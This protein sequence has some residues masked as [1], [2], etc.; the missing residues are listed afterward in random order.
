VT[1]EDDS[2]TIS[3]SNTTT[4]NIDNN[5]SPYNTG[6][7]VMSV[8]ADKNFDNN[9]ITL[10]NFNVTVNGQ[11]TTLDSITLE[12][13]NAVSATYNFTFTYDTGDG[14]E[15]TETGTMIF[16]KT[17]PDAGTYSVQLDNPIAG[18][19]TLETA[20]GSA[21]VG[22]ELNTSTPDNTQPA[23]AVTTIVE[24][25]GP[26]AE[27]GFYVQFT[28]FSAGNGSH[29]TLEGAANQ[30]VEG[31]LFSEGTSLHQSWVSVSGGSNGVAGD[32]VNGPDVLNF[33]LYSSNPTGSFA[34]QEGTTPTASASDMYLVF[35]GIG[36]SDDFIV[37]LKLWGDTNNDGIIDANEIT[38]RAVVVEA[39]DIYRFDATNEAT[40][41][42]TLT[43]TPYEGVVND[44]VALGGSNNND[45]LVIIESNDYNLAG[46]NYQ[47]VGAQIVNTNA[48]VSGSGI[49]LD[50]GV[51]EDGQSTGSQSFAIVDDTAPM[52]ITNIG[53]LTGTSEDQSA[54]I[55][56]DLTV[57]DS[58]GDTATQSYTVNVGDYPA[59]TNEPSAMEAP[60]TK[61]STTTTN[62]TLIA[63][64]T[65]EQQAANTNAVLLGAIAGAGLMSA[66]AAAAAP[67]FD[68]AGLHNDGGFSQSSLLSSTSLQSLDRGDLVPN[69]DS[70][71]LA[72]NVDRMV[73]SDG[74]SFE[75]Q[76]VASEGLTGHDSAEAPAA[77]AQLPQGNDVPAASQAADASSFATGDVAM[78]SLEAL[79][80][81]VG[82]HGAAAQQAGDVAQ[83]LADAL[84]GGGGA[85]IDGLLAS[86]PGG[87]GISADML[88]S[89]DMPSVSAWDMGAFGGFTGMHQAFTMET[90]VLHQ[91]AA[92][93]Q[94]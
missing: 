8:G 62:S 81:S 54:Q 27:D 58:D 12:T 76:S 79:M 69:F 94:A 82:Q 32:T 43:G 60:V 65:S 72:S 75:L 49:N 29:E 91:D 37:V 87:G 52:K 14:G 83:V 84:A 30:W 73:G 42:A 56:F 23:V 88:A 17:G 61:V 90:L 50:S 53:F 74:A 2:P 28:G 78:P 34:E 92:I 44:I 85:D 3:G 13:E 45:G 86:L 9:D 47:I 15:V 66:S 51:G 24:E 33:N 59:D 46:E 31:D 5:T 63:S 71:G 67:A 16:Y 21:F 80:A 64:S 89:H 7:F 18:F 93:Q 6:T 19:S 55:S 40:T 57:T 77:V 35:D 70:S 26:G 41:V 1:V 20:D 10:S 39:G 11:E 38:T 25:S 48:G 4:L 22:Y 68:F 36:A